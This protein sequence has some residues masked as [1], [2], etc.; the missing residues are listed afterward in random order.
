MRYQPIIKKRRAASVIE[1][2]VVLPITF[3]LLLAIMI[4]GIGIIRYQQMAFIARETARFASVH[5]AQYA[6]KNAG[7]IAAGTLPNVDAAYLVNYAKSKAAA[8]DPSQLQVAIS[9]T[10]IK[11]AATAAGATETVDWDNTIENQD[12][13]PYSAWTDTSTDPPSN[14][15]VCNTVTVQVTYRWSPG[16]FGVGPIDLTNTAVL[17]MSY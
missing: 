8:L 17:G 10:V 4:G 13:S 7:A 2:A 16:L 9:I 15:Q 3:T 1:A 5:G 11:P 12:R 6:K 14:K